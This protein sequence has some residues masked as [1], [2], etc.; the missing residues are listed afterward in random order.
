MHRFKLKYFLLILFCLFTL[1]CSE[2]G[3]SSPS[4]SETSANQTSGVKALYFAP[5]QLEAHF[6]KHA[7]QFG[8]ISQEDYL[9]DARALLNAPPGKNILEKVRPNGD[10]LHYKISTGEFAVMTSDGRIRTYFKTNYQ[11]WM[12]Q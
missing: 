9:E 4:V 10:V 12:R 2:R 6:L 11:Y 3:S 7:Y 5:G 1:S 8:D